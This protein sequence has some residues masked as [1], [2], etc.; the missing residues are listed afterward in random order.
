MRTWIARREMYGAPSTLLPELAD[1]NPSPYKTHLRMTV[2]KFEELLGNV[3]TKISRTNT[4]MRNAIPLRTKLEITLRY[5]ASGDSYQS[6][7][8]LYRV[9]KCTVSTFVPVSYTHLDVYKRQIQSSA[10]YILAHLKIPQFTIKS[11]AFNIY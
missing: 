2:K 3:E 5:L 10:L 8:Y 6:L 7:E 9:R 4:T 1:E 11:S